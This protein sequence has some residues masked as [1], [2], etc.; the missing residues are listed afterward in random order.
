MCFRIKETHKHPAR[1]FSYVLRAGFV[2]CKKPF[3]YRPFRVKYPCREEETSKISKDFQRV[4]EGGME[5][6]TFIRIKTWSETSA[7]LRHNEGHVARHELRWYR[8]SNVLRDRG[9]LF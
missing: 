5:T 3:V 1:R 6:G 9:V 7:A 4:S 2:L 8:V